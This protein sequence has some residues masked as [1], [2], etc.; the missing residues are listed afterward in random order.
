M[1]PTTLVQLDYIILPCRSIST[2]RAFYLNVVG[3]RLV[4]DHPEWVRFDCGAT[5]LALRPRG[6]WLMW[7]DK[8]VPK[9][10][11]S[12]QLAFQVQYDA[13]DRWHSYLLREEVIIVEGPVD[14]DFGHRTLFFRDPDYNVIE[15]FAV[16]D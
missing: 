15:I 10:S 9:Q 13:V 7:N 11:V 2:A 16:I 12:V 6:K 14:Q 5:F 1:K 4:E 8:D 3:L